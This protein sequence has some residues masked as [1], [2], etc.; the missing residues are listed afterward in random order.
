MFPLKCNCEISL[1][2]WEY[3][4]GCIYTMFDNFRKANELNII[5]VIQSRAYKIRAFTHNRMNKIHTHAQPSDR[6]I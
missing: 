2:V 4:M 3:Y 5:F 1:A 6:L